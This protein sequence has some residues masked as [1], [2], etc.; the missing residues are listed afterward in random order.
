MRQ[1]VTLTG[2]GTH[3]FKAA[4]ESIMFIHSMFAK[5]I[6][7]TKMDNW[8]PK[9]YHGQQTVQSWNR[10]FT[11]WKDADLIPHPFNELVDP[12]GILGSLDGGNLVHTVD[13]EV[14]YFERTE[15]KN[16]SFK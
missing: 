8:S 11:G 9:Y 10:Y 2:F 16:G 4:L 14:K 7:T 5:E 6:G 15:R 13:N 1:A 12:N 3:K